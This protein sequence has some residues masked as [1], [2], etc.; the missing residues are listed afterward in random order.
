M[1]DEVSKVLSY[2]RAAL[3]DSQL[4]RGAFSAAQVRGLNG[5]GIT[6]DQL[7]AQ[8]V[9]LNDA[10]L[11]SAEDQAATVTPGD[12]GNWFQGLEADW[13]RCVV[14]PYVYLRGSAHQHGAKFRALAPEMFAPVSFTVLVNREGKLISHGR[15]GIA[16]EL[17]E[18]AH[19][20]QPLILGSLKDLDDFF[21]REDFPDFLDEHEPNISER[22]ELKD[23]LEYCE[24]ILD[25]VV[26]IS[27]NEP[28][29]DDAKA[30]YSLTHQGLIHK[31]QQI[32]TAV[33]PLIET[34]DAALDAKKINQVFRSVALGTNLGD[35]AKPKE[36]YA[37]FVRGRDLGD[38][39]KQAVSHIIGG[40]EGCAMSVSGPPGTGKTTILQDMAANLLVDAAMQGNEPPLL[41]VSSTNNQA[42]T[43]VLDSFN[44]VDHR[45]FGVLGERWIEAP[46]SLGVFI[47]SHQRSESARKEGY[48]TPEAIEEH[49]NSVDISEQEQTYIGKAAKC[50]P[51]VRADDDVGAVTVA[52]QEMMKDVLQ[53]IR[54]VGRLEDDFKGLKNR[55]SFGKFRMHLS[56]ISKKVTR[57]GG[58]ALASGAPQ[59]KVFLE[60]LGEYDRALTRHR[61]E[62]E[63]V[64]EQ[65]KAYEKTVSELPGWLVAL[66]SAPGFKGLYHKHLIKQCGDNPLTK[67]QVKRR[68]QEV[69]G[70]FRESVTSI[71]NDQG[72]SYL[73]PSIEQL[74]ETSLRP[75]LF[76][77]S[78]RF[79]EGKW[80]AEM[81]STLKA[82]DP[83]K[84]SFTKTERKWRRRAKLHPVMVSTLHSL[85]RHLNYWDHLAGQELPAFN[86]LDWLVVDEAGQVS[87]DVAG[88]SLCL[89]KRL[90]AVGD[91][92]QIEPVWSISQQIDMGNLA[93]TGMI[94]T[95]QDVE[96]QF[97]A[98][99]ARGITASTGNLISAVKAT[100]KTPLMLT[101]HRRCVPD[102]IRFCNELCYDNQLA[103]LRDP[104][105]SK[106]PAVGYW[107]VPGVCSQAGGSR[108]N[109][110]EAMA[111]ATLVLQN[112][113]EWKASCYEPALSKL[114]AIVTPF[115]QQAVAIQNALRNVIGKEA[116]E[117]T[118]GTIH[119][120]QGAQRPVIIFS[121]AYSAH[122]ANNVFF[123]ETPNMLN[124]AVSRAE[125]HFF[126]VGDMDVLR[127]SVGPGKSL[128]QHLNKLGQPYR[129]V[130]RSDPIREALEDQWG[131]AP[132]LE[133]KG[134]EEHNDYLSDLLRRTN[135]SELMIVT[136]LLTPDSLRSHGNDLISCAQQGKRIEIVTSRQLNYGG[137]WSEMFGRGCELLQSKGVFVRVVDFLTHGALF[138]NGGQE[139]HITHGSWLGADDAGAFN[140]PAAHLVEPQSLRLQTDNLASEHRRARIGL[141]LEYAESESA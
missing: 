31:A 119:S 24:K 79:Y 59:T 69:S 29:I 133:L 6:L 108:K 121:S 90:I 47:A 131:E 103:A 112:K 52:I 136:P 64:K 78:L 93:S 30:R 46:E 48:L 44:R 140:G 82:G 105:V 60:L 122:R 95:K 141:G 25:E 66:R 22:W 106:I 61:R 107:H 113:D 71:Q 56:R 70:E 74:V 123:D 116:D 54:L 2:W 63:K 16:R 3:A 102:I 73:A 128:F 135:V 8:S 42:V 55:E 85:P 91:D 77:L 28:L 17:L 137:E 37:S 68:L 118:V 117:I 50:I 125:D 109:H 34:F 9:E 12:L 26:T 89:T 36:R 120:L 114:L 27:L 11:A 88:P 1:S 35:A 51:G 83:D 84:R 92:A 97:A 23:V 86:F 139:W 65:S 45:D 38:D 124:V 80:L 10:W 62:T 49:E 130:L 87:V 134:F 14:Y 129:G 127:S 13:V 104:K 67:E 15:P 39:Q 76:M 111:V 19:T 21:D 32:S 96:R 57:Y 72:L 115:R 126:F 101:G 43:N 99:S 40:P 18:P 75:T 138:V 100:E 7:K 132:N 98:L 4:G 20:G 53:T 110:V 33:R 94:D 5:R 81:K 41:L 58:V